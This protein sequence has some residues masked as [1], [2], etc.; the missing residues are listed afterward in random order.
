LRAFLSFSFLVLSFFFRLFPLRR[1]DTSWLFFF[2]P[3]YLHGLS[4]RHLRPFLD[5]ADGF[6][7]FPF[8]FP[9]SSGILSHP[10]RTPVKVVAFNILASLHL[11]DQIHFLP[12][13]MESPGLSLKSTVLVAFPEDRG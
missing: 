11:P 9:L 5:F 10:A 7:F 1:T 6:P 8:L 12:L 4:H 3:A 2:P 13:K